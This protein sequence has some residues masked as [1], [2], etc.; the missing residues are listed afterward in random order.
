[1]VV[2]GSLVSIV[3]CIRWYVSGW[4]VG[5]GEVVHWELDDV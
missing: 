3:G 5:M 1:M 2:W 4:G